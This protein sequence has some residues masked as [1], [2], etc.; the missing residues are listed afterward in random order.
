[1][2]VRVFSRFG[3]SPCFEK[4]QQHYEIKYPNHPQKRA[5]YAGANDAAQTLHRGQVVLDGRCCE[6][7]TYGKGEDDRRM[8]QREEKSDPQRSLALLQHVPHRVVDR[9]D[10]VRVEGMPQAE[11]VGD[12]AQADQRLVA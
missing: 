7:D 6:D 9:R 5:G 1:M 2:G 11:H 10:M 12:E 3:L 8:T 4:F